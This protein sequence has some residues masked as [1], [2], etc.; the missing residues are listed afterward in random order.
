MEKTEPMMLMEWPM[1][2]YF[3]EP[4]PSVKK[5]F[6]SPLDVAPS[7][8]R[9]WALDEDPAASP[10]ELALIASTHSDISRSSRAWK[11]YS[12]PLDN[13]KKMQNMHLDKH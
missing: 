10:D 4:F 6:F 8:G 1:P 5:P 3:L 7:A 13:L 11:R 9:V 12:P 2:A